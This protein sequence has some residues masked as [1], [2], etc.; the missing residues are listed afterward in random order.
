M[1]WISVDKKLPNPGEL[2][3]CYCNKGGI[4][5]ARYSDVYNRW[6]V[7]GTI[8]ITHWMPLPT[9]PEVKE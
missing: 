8:N 3:L 4:I 9:P 7:A 6:R 2:V 1:E 5:L